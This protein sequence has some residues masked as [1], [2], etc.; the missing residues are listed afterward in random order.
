M[1][2]LDLLTIPLSWCYALGVGVR[3]LL[4]DEH[5]L[6]SH[7]VSV[8]TICVGNLAVGGTGKTPHVEYLLR[9]LS[10]H[11]KVAVLSRGYKRKTHGFV[12]ADAS[13]NASTIGDE[14]MQIHSKFPHVPVAVC[15]DRVKGVRLLQKWIEGLQVVLLDDA[16]Q[17]RAICC[18]YYILLT[19]C[20]QLY[21][22]D[23]LLPWGR[24]RDLK[25]QS[26]KA[27]MIIV[28][29]CP[30]DMQ[31]IDQRVISNRLGLATF[32]Q[33]CFS[34]IRY[35]EI[36]AQGRPLVVTGIAQTDYL[37]EHIRRQFP[38]AELMAFSD[39]H[40]F[41]PADIRRIEERARGFDFVLTTEKDYQRFLLTPLPE[42]LGDRL[43]TIPIEVDLRDQ[44]FDF[45]QAILAYVRE[46]LRKER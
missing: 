1:R 22:D 37:M 39:H 44:Q 13:S 12:I 11:Y 7:T 36:A 20:D 24:L 30:D 10:R 19:P 3:H 5:I 46:A 6:P 29:K 31:P 28:T 32:Q 25:E 18:G 41:T 15:E 17:H 16:Y 42:H 35:G 21:I 43:Q 38:K 9:L 27:N 14:A 23:H 8:P 33:L 2:P 34:H 26:Q 45:E 40:A 4:Y